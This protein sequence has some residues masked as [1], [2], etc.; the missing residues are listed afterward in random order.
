MKRRITYLAADAVAAAAAGD[1]EGESRSASAETERL[2]Q[3]GSA[4]SV[5]CCGRHFPH[6]RHCCRFSLLAA[7]AA[8]SASIPA[9]V[10]SILLSEKRPSHSGNDEEFF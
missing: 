4:Y 6:S 1:G 5:R 8:S 10:S 9:T 2:Y 7:T 3:R